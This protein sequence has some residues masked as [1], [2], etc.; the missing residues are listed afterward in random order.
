MA[1]E[2]KDAMA[3]ESNGTKKRICTTSEGAGSEPSGVVSGILGL[4]R[5][6][7]PERGDDRVPRKVKR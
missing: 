7:G 5:K 4:P 3:K 1:L 6:A 2:K